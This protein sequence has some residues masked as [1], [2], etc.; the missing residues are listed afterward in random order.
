[1]GSFEGHSLPVRDLCFS[2]DGDRVITAA[3]DSR[4]K[5]RHAKLRWVRYPAR[6]VIIFVDRIWLMDNGIA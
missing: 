5:V 6:L 2:H 4:V 1:M 3:E